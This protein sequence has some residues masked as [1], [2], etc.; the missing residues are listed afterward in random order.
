MLGLARNTAGELCA[1][2]VPLARLGRGGWKKRIY[3][4]SS[5][6]TTTRFAWPG[7]GWCLHRAIAQFSSTSLAP[8][9]KNFKKL[10]FRYRSV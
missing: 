4:G 7:V 2:R 6:L 1:V 10:A 3:L 5:S 9:S 8:D